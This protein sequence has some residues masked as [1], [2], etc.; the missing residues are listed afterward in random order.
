MSKFL[1]E[2]GQEL[3]GTIHIQS[4]KNA[5][6]PIL[7]SIPL[8]NGHSIIRDVPRISDIE[9]LLHI[10]AG[11]GVKVKWQD[12]DLHLDS[13][14]LYMNEINSEIAK[15]IRGSIL[16]MG[17]LVG[18]FGATKLA[19]PGGCNIGSRPVDLHLN[20]FRELGVAIKESNDFI[21]CNAKR[22]KGGAVYLDFA[23]VGATENLILVSVLGKRSVKI[24]NSAKEPEIVDLC[25][26]LRKCG[27]C[28]SGD[29]TDTI[30]IQGVKEL[31]GTDHK[32]IPDRINTGSYMLAVA[33]VGGDVTLENVAPEHN[34]PLI[35]KL[36]KDGID[37]THT[38]DTI[39]IRADKNSKALNKKRNVSHQTSQY[40]GFSTDLQS[41]LG[42]FSC[43]RKGTTTITE[44]L[45][46]GRFRCYE[47]LKKVGTNVCI[48]GRKVFITGVK[49]FKGGCTEKPITVTAS[50]LRSGVG[51]VIAG[52]A[53][54]GH[55][56]VERADIVARGHEDIVRDLTKVGARIS[57][58]E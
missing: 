56:I 37:V 16:L 2:G 40:P 12:G 46:E 30:I 20:G 49:E 39:R 53:A 58:I 23:S 13:T 5:C 22:F 27:A 50:D 33:T 26:F 3:H 6:L 8:T 45:F 21:E 10:L 17:S 57:L 7:A 34:Y 14:N 15:K 24:V 38:N 28:I 18:R 31:G 42:V 35:K 4:G 25:D 11:I 48:S 29:G 55:T 41:Q 36:I 19:Y 43:L 1:I 51:L 47:E 54:R 32:P 44:N 52:M 9:N